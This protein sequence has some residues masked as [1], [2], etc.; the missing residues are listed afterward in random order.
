MGKSEKS[1]VE[2]PESDVDELF[3]GQSEDEELL[4]HLQAG[5]LELPDGWTVEVYS[6][7]LEGS[8]PEGWVEDQWQQFSREQL[9]IIESQEM[10]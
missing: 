8:I 6:E 1:V 3:E 9:E 10:L 5:E 7:W 4:H 2:L